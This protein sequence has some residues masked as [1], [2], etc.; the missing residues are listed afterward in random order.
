MHIIHTL[1]TSATLFQFFFFFYLPTARRRTLFLSRCIA[2][3][4]MNKCWREI[5]C[6]QHAKGKLIALKLIWP[7]SAVFLVSANNTPECWISARTAFWEVMLLSLFTSKAANNICLTSQ[8]I[9]KKGKGSQNVQLWCGFV[10]AAVY[11]I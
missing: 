10:K 2:Y 5:R 4:W 1:N 11:K 9:F 7:R 3:G 8:N 6:Y